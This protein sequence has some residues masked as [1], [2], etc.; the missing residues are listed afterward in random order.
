M[1][2]LIKSGKL[3]VEKRSV[4]FD[5]LT[6]GENLCVSKFSQPTERKNGGKGRGFWSSWRSWIRL[7]LRRRVTEASVASAAG[8]A[9]PNMDRQSSP[10][11]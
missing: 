9:P 2:C 6:R 5:N 3:V 7:A 10:C 11:P 4:L 8:A 1:Q